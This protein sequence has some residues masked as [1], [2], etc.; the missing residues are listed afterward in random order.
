M[1]GKLS[2]KNQFFIMSYLRCLKWS[3]CWERLLANVPSLQIPPFL[4]LRL[5]FLHLY[6]G[7]SLTRTWNLHAPGKKCDVSGT[8][9]QQVL[10]L[11]LITDHHL[12]A[13]S[14]QLLTI[15]T[16][17]LWIVKWGFFGDMCCF[18]Y[19]KKEK[20]HKTRQT[21]EFPQN[22]YQLTFSVALRKITIWL[23]LQLSLTWSGDL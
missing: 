10:Y 22:H 4:V 6:F 15:W 12:Y 16:W 8:S 20:I 17:S 14:W 5:Y 11:Y 18:L 13:G 9:H 2:H 3:I 7:E 23:E 21:P 1:S 19:S